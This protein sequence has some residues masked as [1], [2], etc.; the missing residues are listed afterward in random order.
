LLNI[1]DTEVKRIVKAL[2]EI[3][4]GKKIIQ[5]NDVI[6]PTVRTAD[7]R[8]AEGK[9]NN[10][11]SPEPHLRTM[12][13]IKDPGAIVGNVIAAIKIVLPQC[14]YMVVKMLK[15]EAG[16]TV[17]IAHTGYV[18]DAIPKPVTHFKAFHYSAV[19]RLL[20]NKSRDEITIPLHAMVLHAGAKYNIKN[21][22]HFISA[23]TATFPASDDF[24]LYF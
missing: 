2:D 6:A 22:R 4:D 21:S 18:P 15:S 12:Q 19:T 1:Q 16:D 9:E 10:F 11:F 8:L 3:H 5:V 14:T 13:P 23:S 7:I 17:Q 24:Q 20:I